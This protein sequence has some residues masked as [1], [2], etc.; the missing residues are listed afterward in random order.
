MR[1]EQIHALQA[2]KAREIRGPLEG[3]PRCLSLQRVGTRT[4]RSD[5]ARCRS[6]TL[7]R[8][9]GVVTWLWLPRASASK[10]AQLR[11]STGCGSRSSR[12]HLHR[13]VSALWGSVCTA[14]HRCGALALPTSNAVARSFALSSRTSSCLQRLRKLLHG[15]AVRGRGSCATRSGARSRARRRGR[16]RSSQQSAGHCRCRRGDRASRR[17]RLDSGTDGRRDER[18]TISRHGLHLRGKGG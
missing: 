12:L 16:V 4:V 6:T 11:V 18:R 5:L 7:D 9:L 10:L 1:A 15:G 3:A 2:G 14:A 8:R 13:H 17:L